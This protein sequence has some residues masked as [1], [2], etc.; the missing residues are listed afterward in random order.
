MM[1]NVQ[2][3]SE[4]LPFHEACKYMSITKQAMYGW[5]RE[6]KVRS[7]RVE[8]KLFVFLIT[9]YRTYDMR[10]FFKIP[11]GTIT[12]SIMQAARA[13][14]VERKTIYRGLDEGKFTAVRTASGLVRILIKTSYPKRFL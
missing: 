7:T 10:K 3:R 1:R 4:L 9:L 11:H 14:G 12:L 6:G 5:I 13:Y 2:E 8:G